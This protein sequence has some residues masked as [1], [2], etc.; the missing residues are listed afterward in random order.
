[1]IRKRRVTSKLLAA[2]GS[3]LMITGGVL[4]L[5]SLGSGGGYFSAALVIAGL[6]FLLVAIL[7]AII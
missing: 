2:I 1:M 4:F 7:K 3:A 5:N 6:A